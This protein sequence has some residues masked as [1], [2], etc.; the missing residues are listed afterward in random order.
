M[1]GIDFLIL[2]SVKEPLV[3]CSRFH[4]PWVFVCKNKTEIWSKH[5]ILRNPHD[6]PIDLQIY[7]NPVL[8]SRK[9]FPQLEFSWKAY[10]AGFYGNFPGFKPWTPLKAD[11][12][13]TGWKWMEKL[14][15]PSIVFWASMFTPEKSEEVHF[16][17]PFVHLCM[18]MLGHAQL[19]KVITPMIPWKW[20]ENGWFMLIF[21]GNHRAFL[22]L[23]V[24]RSRVETLS[25]D[26]R[27]LQLNDWI[28][29]TWTCRNV[30]LCHLWDLDT[31]THSKS[32]HW[33]IIFQ[34]H[35]LWVSTF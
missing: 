12:Y 22:Y 26:L 20:M 32:T 13:G 27:S 11:G 29:W 5:K 7:D 15:K 17:K 19:G 16:R 1:G 28:C 33:K 35:W 21:I 14:G 18:L 4:I 25:S 8:F 10:E 3:V 31:V 6:I 34:I 24:G 30:S 9:A 2:W 23:S